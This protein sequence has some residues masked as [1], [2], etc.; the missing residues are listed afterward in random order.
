VPF[1][2]GGLLVVISDF[3]FFMTGGLPDFAFLDCGLSDPLIEDAAL[4]GFLTLF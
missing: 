1:F 2:S 4:I 3:A